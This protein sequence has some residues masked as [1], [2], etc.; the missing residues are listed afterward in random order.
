MRLKEGENN[1]GCGRTSC[2][3]NTDILPLYNVGM[4]HVFAQQHIHFE[5]CFWPPDQCRF[6]IH[7][8]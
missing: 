4:V 7:S 6:N 8:V 5:P 1:L 3:R 2:Q